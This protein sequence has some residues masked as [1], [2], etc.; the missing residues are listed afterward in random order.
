MGWI[1]YG[2][3]RHP[4]F[5]P[6]NNAQKTS[7]SI[8]IPFRNEEKHLPFLLKTLLNVKYDLTKFEILFVDDD[9][10]DTSVEIIHTFLKDAPLYFEILSNK[11]YSNSPKKDA[12][13]LAAKQARHSW[14]VTTDADCKIPE[15]WLVLLDAFIQKEHPK[16]VCMPVFLERDDSFLKQYQFF[17]VLS[18]Q[19]TTLGGFG[20]NIPLLCNG[21]NL[22]YKKNAFFEVAGFI[23]ND[24]HASGDDIFLMEKIKALYPNKI[25]YLKNP[26]AAIITHCVESWEE[27]IQQRIRW[28]SKTK[29][30]KN[31]A[32]SLVGGIALLT[33]LTLVIS[34]I[35][36]FIFPLKILYFALFILL[37]IM[38]DSIILV[39]EARFL[40]LKINLFYVFLSSFV[41][42]FMVVWVV[43]NS[44]HGAY[45][46]KD[47]TFKK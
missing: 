38:L 1:F 40:K 46:W 19:A 5:F 29:Y 47:R 9:S 16:M 24:K 35:F 10:S 8:I 6:K 41:Y 26:E 31:A 17:D 32:V 21:A 7:F 18:L 37:K 33:N 25:K 14:I 13:S 45:Q 42:S 39:V 2:I 30:L 43:L 11:R 27:I 28:A 4:A 3:K 36:S 15:K 23:N 34:L 44:F 22:A 20:N 12:I